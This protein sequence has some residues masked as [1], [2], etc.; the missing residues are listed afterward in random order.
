MQQLAVELLL[1][2]K[3][4]HA[5]TTPAALIIIIMLP[6]SH[7]TGSP[8]LHLK[9]RCCS[10]TKIAQATAAAAPKHAASNIAPQHQQ[11]TLLQAS[12]QGL[13]A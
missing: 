7:Y 3:Q 4:A 13:T 2:P 10:C 11:L 6:I 9:L 8:Q 1:L 12:L 5:A